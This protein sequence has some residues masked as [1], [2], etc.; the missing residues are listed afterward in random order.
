MHPIQAI[1]AFFRVFFKGEA[2][3]AAAAPPP[4]DD[5]FKPSSEPAIQLLGLFQK[6]G[7]LLDFLREDIASYSDADVGSAVREIHAGCRR[8]IDERITLE[9]ILEGSDGDSVEVPADFD[10]SAVALEGNLPAEGPYRGVL[11]HGGWRVAEMRLPTAAAG[12][13]PRVAAP[14]QV[15]VG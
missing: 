10:P 4:P 6:E 9:R 14:A 11:R 3:V 1:R 8:V 12:A 13:D 7:R 2:A 15:D 5:A